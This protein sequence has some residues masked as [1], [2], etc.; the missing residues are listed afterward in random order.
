MH[1][2]VAAAI[3]RECREPGVREAADAELAAFWDAVFDWARERE[4]GEDSALVVR[5]GLAAAP[6][7]LRRGDWRHRELPA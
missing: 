4:G 6:Y 5:A 7:L 2:G 3:T 1:P